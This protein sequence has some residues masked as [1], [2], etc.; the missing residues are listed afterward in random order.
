MMFQPDEDEHVLCLY[1]NDQDCG[2]VCKESDYK[3]TNDQTG[4]LLKDRFIF[5]LKTAQMYIERQ[6]LVAEIIPPL[7]TSPPKVTP[8]SETEIKINSPRI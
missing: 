1:I 4:I 2:G 8:S 6:L 5:C 3:I 7:C